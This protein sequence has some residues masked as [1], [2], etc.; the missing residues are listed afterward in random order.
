[1]KDQKQFVINSATTSDFGA[2][3]QSI[4]ENY[5]PF[6][7]QCTREEYHECNNVDG[8]I[9]PPQILVTCTEAQVRDLKGSFDYFEA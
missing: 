5:I 8:S 3:L 4:V 7:T 6:N 1:M 2:I 9:V